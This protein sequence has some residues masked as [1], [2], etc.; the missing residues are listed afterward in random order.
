MEKTHHSNSEKHVRGAAPVILSCGPASWLVPTMKRP[1]A[2]SVI[3]SAA[4]DLATGWI[5]TVGL[6]ADFSPVGQMLHFVQHDKC[7]RHYFISS[8]SERS[9]HR[10]GSFSRLQA[11]SFTSLCS[12]QD[13]KRRAGVLRNLYRSGISIGIVSLIVL[14]LFGR[15]HVRA[16]EGSRYLQAVQRFADTVL[17]QGRDTYGE[18]HTPLFADGLHAKTL[19]PAT[20]RW[21]NETWIL[22]NF[23]SQQPLVR[24]L[25]GLT[26]LTG[27]PKY[28]QAAEDAARYALKHLTTPNGLLYWGGHF[29]WDLQADRHVGQYSD[30]HEL[31]NHE[32]YFSLMWRVCPEE[33]SRLMAAIWAGHILDWSR[34]DYNRHA[35]VTKSVRIPWDHAFAQDLDVPFTAQGSNLSFVNVTPP[36]MHSGIMLAALNDNADALTWTRRLLYRWQQAEHPVTGLSGGQLSYRK[37]DRAQDALG[38]VHPAINEAK[39]VA[40]YHQTNRYHDLPLAQMQAACT[41][42]RK[43][44]RYADVGRELIHWASEDLKAYARYSFDP[45]SDRFV[46]LMTDGTPLQWEKS[47][48]GYYVPESFAPRRPDGFIL[49]GYALAYRL[50]G[51]DAHWQ[52]VRRLAESLSLGD[53]G[54]PEGTERALHFGTDSADWRCVYALL[55]LQRARPDPRFL[56]LA[57]RIADNILRTQT[58][59]GLFPR[60]GRQ[61]ARTGDEVPLALLHLAASLTGKSERMPAP[62]RD[63]RFFHCEYHGELE[64]YQQKRADKRTY[65]DYVY[66]GSR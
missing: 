55:E 6:D 12:A 66:Y 44:G 48:E 32:P 54:E 50:T 29:A 60:S 40:S 8:D 53:I 47:R 18:Q 23:A 24:T 1:L 59:T 5:A 34:L 37:N 16:D 13:D 61:W 41:L 30:V 20:W 10:M 65:D 43:G 2:K 58:E 42:L 49:W 45:N 35:S 62:I 46:A 15:G 36:L 21:K 57:S 14:S 64:D 56:R 22:S 3:L 19:K 4:K 38:H 28:R 25:D 9:G 27:E 52:M 17:E 26:A 33:T 63:S 11:G 39:I 31:K 51:D 7:Y